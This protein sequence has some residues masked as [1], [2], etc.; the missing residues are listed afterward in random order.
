MYIISRP[1]IS[2]SKPVEVGWHLFCSPCAKKTLIAF[3]LGATEENL[4]ETER[5]MDNWGKGEGVL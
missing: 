3:S 4:K 1:C 2:C 5:L